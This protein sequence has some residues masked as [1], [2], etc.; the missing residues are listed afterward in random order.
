MMP[1]TTKTRF[2]P[3]P[4]G[5][6]HLGNVRTALFNAL[7]AR[8]A[9]GI[10]VLR[11]E[12]TD[13][14][15]SR[16]RYATALQ[17][18]L[19]WL[20]L[21]WQEGPNAG[22]GAGPYLQSQRGDIYS[23]Y[24][25]VLRDKGLS[26]PCFCSPQELESARR[27]QRRAGQP[28]RYPGTCARLDAAQVQAR[29]DQG[30]K[31]TLRFRVPAGRAVEFHDLV[32]GPQRIASDAIGDFIIR[33]ADGTPAF[34]FS[35]A[36]DDALMG[37]THVLRGEDHLTNTPR[38]LLLLQALELTA[39]A[40]GHISMI[41]AADGSPLSKRQGSR[42]VAEL[43]RAGFLP[44]AILNHLARLGHSYQQG[45]YMDL[46]G[47]AAGFELDHLGRAPARHDETQLEHWQKQ[48]LAA[49]GEDDLWQ[50]MKQDDDAPDG[51]DA[52][53]PAGQIHAFVAAV[54]DNVLLPAD[55]RLWALRL[56]G[57]PGDY[58]PE[59]D[60]AI[61]AAGAGFYRAALS[62]EA[63]DGRDFRA[64]AKRLGAAAGVKGRQLFMPLRA[65]LTGITPQSAGAAGRDAVRWQHGPELARL[66]ELLGPQRVRERLQAALR[67]CETD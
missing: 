31:P 46:D 24:Y 19:R 25:G 6:L 48:A 30:L 41:V 2:A 54:R 29:L 39:P 55:A 52:R 44:G 66:W 8:R 15:R 5:E 64:F 53:V 16:D 18:D 32:R 7:L 22:G 33:R 36:V 43:R 49:A 4:T 61:R 63:Q 3:S 27:A 28:P 34:F 38:Q 35:N 45:A 17:G 14:E 47:L 57:S 37:V 13:R 20:G 1:P 59:A 23:R 50:W 51:I 42:S 21:E 65:A 62:E 67:L 60:M 26:Y 11:I 10:F 40:Y 12:D 58:D 9:G 56:Y